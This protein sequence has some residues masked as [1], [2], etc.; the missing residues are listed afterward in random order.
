MVKAAM[1]SSEETSIIKADVFIV[2]IFWV[3]ELKY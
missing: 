2:G 3:D 1:I